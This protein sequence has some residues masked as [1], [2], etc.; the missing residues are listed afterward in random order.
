MHEYL[1]VSRLEKK[2]LSF[3]VGRPSKS[4]ALKSR[5]VRRVQDFV[6]LGLKKSEASKSGD[7]RRAQD[8]VE[9]AIKKFRPKGI[10]IIMP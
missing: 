2:I 9:L 1:G 5:D 6:E 7:V 3:E 4:E 10:I 8:F